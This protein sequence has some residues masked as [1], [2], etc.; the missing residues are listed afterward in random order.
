M[1]ATKKMKNV[2][3]G[4]IAVALLSV[5]LFADTGAASRY[6]NQVQTA[7]THK[8]DAK[9]QFRDVKAS[10]E[11]GIVTLTG[12]VDLYQRKLDAAKLARKAAHVQGV[13]NLITVGGP[14]V[15][16]AQLEQKLATK[17]RYVRVGYDNAFDY[18]ALGV[19]DGVVT[20]EGQDRTGVGRDE[21]FAEVANM[22]GVK[23][24]INN[25]SIAPV[26]TFDDGVR[27]QALQAIYRDPVLSKYAMDPAHPI[28]I[29]VANGHVTL[30]GSVDNAMDKNIAGIRANQIFGAF[31]VDNKLVVDKS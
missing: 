24:V 30:Y 19:K 7:V 29:I 28:R 16:D 25:I 31:T 26:S 10:V 5:T 12:S 17:L 22:P 2:A 13:R 20:V 1:Q 9:K 21:A 14:D 8:L 27:I 11:D 15:P 3:G 6:D 23:D 4:L 18:F